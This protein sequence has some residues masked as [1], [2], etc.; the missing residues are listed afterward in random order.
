LRIRRPLGFVVA[1]HDSGR[2]GNL[3]QVRQLQA[4]KDVPQERVG[5]PSDLVTGGRRNLAQI[6]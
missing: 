5:L 2:I 6:K 1:L 3:F 4:R